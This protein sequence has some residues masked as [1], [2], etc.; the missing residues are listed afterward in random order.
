MSC[1]FFSR[2]ALWGRALADTRPAAQAVGRGCQIGARF[3]LPNLATLPNPSTAAARVARLGREIWPQSGNPGCEVQQD[4]L[5]PFFFFAP[6]DWTRRRLRNFMKLFKQHLAPSLQCQFLSG[7]Y[8]QGP[9]YNK[10]KHMQSLLPSGTF[11]KKKT[12]LL[13][14]EYWWNSI[15]I[16]GFYHM[17]VLFS[18]SR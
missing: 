10:E 11:T 17:C 2:L 1:V 9:I 16:W 8:Q 5:V 18:S 13:L 4:K 3:P 6:F 12:Q 14:E 15:Y 7:P